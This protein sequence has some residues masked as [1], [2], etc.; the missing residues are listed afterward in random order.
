MHLLAL[1]TAEAGSSFVG[2]GGVFPAAWSPLCVAI[3]CRVGKRLEPAE[4]N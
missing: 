1:V 2:I 4:S 3:E